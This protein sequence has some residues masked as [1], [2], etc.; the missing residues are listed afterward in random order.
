MMRSCDTRSERIDEIEK[1]EHCEEL[2]NMD[3]DIQ[4]EVAREGTRRRGEELPGRR[5]QLGLG[6]RVPP[7]EW[8][9]SF[10]DSRC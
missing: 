5:L 10:G 3:V 4:G 7:R 8:I 1:P 9:S 2:V 6:L